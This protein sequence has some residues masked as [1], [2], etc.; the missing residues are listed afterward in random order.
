M[1]SIATEPVSRS[2]LNTCL[3]ICFDL[4]GHGPPSATSTHVRRLQWTFLACLQLCLE[5]NRVLRYQCHGGSS[6]SH[7]TRIPS[8]LMRYP[9][10]NQPA[11][12]RRVKSSRGGRG[13]DSERNMSEDE[14]RY[15]SRIQRNR[16]RER[17]FKPGL[18]RPNPR[19]KSTDSTRKSRHN[20]LQPTYIDDDDRG[21]LLLAYRVFLALL[22][23]CV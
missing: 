10:E 6:Q 13:R 16:E 14:A 15:R 12:T 20:H 9:Q 21:R 19:S 2:T 18:T 11:S 8:M 5:R 3:G 23:W 4:D 17:R 22:S 7:P 1:L